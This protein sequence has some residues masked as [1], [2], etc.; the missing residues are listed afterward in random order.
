MP[1]LQFRLCY[2]VE[3]RY[4]VIHDVARAVAI[5]KPVDLGMGFVHVVWQRDASARAIQSLAMAGSPPV[6]LN[7]TGV[8]RVSIRWLAERCGERLGLTPVYC[9]GAEGM[10]AW[11]WDARRAEA[12]FGPPETTTEE[13]VAM[14]C[15]WI[16]RGG[17]SLGRP[18][19]FEVRDGAF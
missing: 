6:A 10:E 11:L 14:V 18:T 1:L 7:V 13:A 19:H 4:G 3:P 15:D 17:A 2:A 12:L 8:E 16:S 9:C 5:G